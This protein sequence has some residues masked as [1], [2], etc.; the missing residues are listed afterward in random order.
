MLAVFCPKYILFR[1]FNVMIN[2]EERR[3]ACVNTVSR[4][5]GEFARHIYLDGCKLKLNVKQISTI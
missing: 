1:T 2:T 3:F 5:N 4:H